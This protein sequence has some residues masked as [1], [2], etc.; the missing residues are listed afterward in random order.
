MDTR[1]QRLSEGVATDAMGSVDSFPFLSDPRRVA[2]LAELAETDD[3]I[4]TATLA[5]RVGAAET[6]KR[7]ADVSS[8]EERIVH[9]SLRHTHLPKLS[10]QSLV[11]WD[12]ESDTVSLSTD[13]SIP[14]L[15]RFLGGRSS[16]AS[17]HLL[18]TL[19]NPR[20]RLIVRLLATH[21]TPMTVDEL[22]RHATAEERAIEPGSLS[23]TEIDH[24][25]VSFVHAHLPAL[26]AA[27]LIEYDESAGVV[28]DV[29]VRD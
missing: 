23:D 9:S 13:V 20:R 3:P 21:G 10:T 22:A 5:R 14:R 1:T 24:V 15:R 29:T 12:R 6:G 28:A 18:R 11:A 17:S 16:M 27:E 8:R 2:I 26:S 25:R 19:S 4:P 7:V